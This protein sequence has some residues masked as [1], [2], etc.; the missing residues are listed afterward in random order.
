MSVFSNLKWI[1]IYFKLSPIFDEL[2]RELGM[3]FSWN[4]VFQIAAT[5]VQGA[6]M[7]GGIL[8]PKAQGIITAGVTVL[9]AV[10][11]LLAHFVNPDGTS[12]KTAYVPTVE[13]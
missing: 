5:V 7:L 11:G 2:G 8:P 9:Q 6:N 3:K 12:A 13:K 1:K 4:L 10:V